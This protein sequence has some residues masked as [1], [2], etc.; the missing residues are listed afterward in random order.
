MTPTHL[1]AYIARGPAGLPA[2]DLPAVLDAMRS[3]RAAAWAQR[4]HQKPGERRP[5]HAVNRLDA[6][7]AEIEH[8]R[9]PTPETAAEVQR[10]A[11]GVA[12]DVR[13]CID[14]GETP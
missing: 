7:I 8:F 2:F 14:H 13:A 11:E 12:W 3:E 5:I 4:D 10:T 1:A 9:N 6:A